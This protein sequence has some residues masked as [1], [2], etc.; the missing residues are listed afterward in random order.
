LKDQGHHHSDKGKILIDS[1]LE[2]MNNN[3]L[4]TSGKSKIN[5]ELLIE[6]AKLMIDSSSNYRIEEGKI[7]IVS[8]NK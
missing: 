6:Q 8:E 3:R 2:Q 1:F 5:R 7:F 4:S